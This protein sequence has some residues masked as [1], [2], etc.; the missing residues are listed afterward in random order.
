MEQ[1]VELEQEEKVKTKVGGTST[2]GRTVETKQVIQLQLKKNNNKWKNCW[3]NIKI[4]KACGDNNNKLY[5]N[6]WPNNKLNKN[7]WFNKWEKTK[8][9]KTG[10]ER[11]AET[12]STGDRLARA[13]DSN[14]SKGDEGTFW[15]FTNWNE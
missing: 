13:I 6:C 10:G 8:I 3:A 4:Y 14:V 1:Q 9:A 11:K 15:I 12:S 5:K 2:S 7:G